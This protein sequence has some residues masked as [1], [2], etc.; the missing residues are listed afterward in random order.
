MR[1]L[2]TPSMKKLISSR[3]RLSPSRFFRMTSCGLKLLSLVTL[4]QNSGLSRYREPLTDRIE[5]F[6][7]LCFHADASGIDT[8]RY[9]DVQTHRID[10]TPNLRR[11]ENDC[12]VDI[13]NV[14]TALPRQPHHAREQFHTVGPTPLRILFRKVNTDVAF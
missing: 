12:R 10:V 1:P 7:R 14:Q 11:F 5:S 8:E 9:C 4:H 6:T 3:D 13:H 2:V